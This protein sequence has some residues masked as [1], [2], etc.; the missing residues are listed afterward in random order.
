MLPTL[1]VRT[2]T[3]RV[4]LVTSLVHLTND[5]CFALIYPVLPLI[6]ADL[7]L[8][9]AQIGLLKASFASAQSFFQIP[10]GVLGE[11]AGEALVLLLGNAWVGVGLAAMALAGGYVPLLLLALVAGLGGNAQHPLA[12]AIVSRA[13]GRARRATALGTLNFAGD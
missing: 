1:P 3:R 5:A 6:A 13:Y 11:R 7:H 10:V 9:Y 4:L 2:T 12:N 8:S